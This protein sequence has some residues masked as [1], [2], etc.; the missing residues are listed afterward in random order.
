VSACIF[1]ESLAHRRDVGAGAEQL[2]EQGQVVVGRL[3]LGQA[4]GVRPQSAHVLA[5]FPGA[6]G[7]RFGL[8]CF[9]GFP[10]AVL[11][12]HHEGATC[13][14]SKKGAGRKTHGNGENCDLQPA[15]RA[16]QR[17]AWHQNGAG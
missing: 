11:H 10:S 13:G 5:Q 4:L 3:D 6:G 9:H 2:A 7:Q 17:G 1:A 8:Q 14:F 12:A 15:Q 16:P